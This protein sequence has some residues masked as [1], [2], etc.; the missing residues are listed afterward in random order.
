LAREAHTVDIRGLFESHLTVSNLG[1]AVR[2]Y[3]DTLKLSLAAEFPERGVAFFWVGAA[4][5]AM[6]GLWETGNGPQRMMLHT[7]FETSVQSVLHA[8]RELKR[9]GLTP[10]D[11]EG[12]PAQEP[13]VLCWMP[14]VAVCFQDPDGNLLEF[15]AMLPDRPRPELGA[16][17]WSEWKQGERVR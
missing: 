16:V 11:L 7:A 12:K 3:R 5:K 13:V 14:A 8:P 6:L 1:R 15:L 10:L 17:P 4:G 9:A 2:F